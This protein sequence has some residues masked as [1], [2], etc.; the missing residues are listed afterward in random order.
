MNQLAWDA[1]AVRM[2]I[3][4]VRMII[5]LED[6]SMIDSPFSFRATG[7]SEDISEKVK[8]VNC[9]QVNVSIY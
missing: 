8:I 4:T 2:K 3:V 6:L 7:Y 1:I 5:L 9:K